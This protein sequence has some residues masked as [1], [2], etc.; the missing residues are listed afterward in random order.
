VRF[1]RTRA[2]ASSASPRRTRGHEPLRSDQDERSGHGRLTD[3]EG[4]VT[5]HEQHLECLERCFEQH[6]FIVEYYGDV[7]P[8][9]DRTP[10]RHGPAAGYHDECAG[11]SRLSYPSRA[12]SARETALPAMKQSLSPFV[13]YLAFFYLAWTFV[14]VYGVYPWANKT[15]G[16]TT[17]LY[18]LVNIFFRLAIWVL[19]VCWYLRY[20][21]RVRILEYLRLKQHWR[22]G[23]IVGLTVSALNCVGTMARFGLPAWTGAYVTW[24]S[25]LGTSIL[26]GVFEEIPFRGF[27]L[28]KLQERFGFATSAVLSSLLFVGAHV[29]GW[30]ML[31]LLTADRILF[32]FAFGVVMAAILR[33]SQSLWACII[34]HSLND[35]LSFVIFHI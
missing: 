22:R 25:I 6:A 9:K 26:V 18:A 15:I 17:L 11:H 13:G 12:R 10:P 5:D 1:S 24:N 16:S 29:P 32:I 20:I 23:V 21:D 14:W 3:A 27:V 8:Q 33:Y 31:G 7:G 4:S 19:P 34:S 2:I 30:I 35:G 28:Q